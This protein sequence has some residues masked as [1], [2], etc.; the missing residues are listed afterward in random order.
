MRIEHNGDI[1]DYICNNFNLKNK[2]VFD[3]GSNVGKM[4]KKFINAGAKVVSIEPQEEL[5]KNGNYKD[6]FAIENV[7]ISNKEGNIIF[8]RGGKAHNVSTCYEH[9]NKHHPKTKWTKV[10]MKCT[11]LDLLIKKYGVPKYIKIDVEG[12]EDKVLSGLSQSVDLISFEFTEGFED[13]FI[14]CINLLEKFNPKKMITFQ[15]IKIKRKKRIPGMSKILKRYCIID[16][17][18]NLTSVI[19]FYKSLPIRTQGDILIQL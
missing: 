10:K 3:V 15:N 2:L 4:T 1:H 12:Y 5:I 11:T 16:E 8:Y 17:F 9:W 13:N 6:V 14:R 19:N 7:C 18:D